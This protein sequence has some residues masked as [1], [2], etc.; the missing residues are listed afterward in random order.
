MIR[1][2]RKRV[3]KVSIQE[4]EWLDVPVE[5]KDNAGTEQSCSRQGWDWQLRGHCWSE[6]PENWERSCWE[7]TGVGRKAAEMEKKRLMGET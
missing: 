6:G 4:Y 5:R 3:V 7:V 1:S 2:Y